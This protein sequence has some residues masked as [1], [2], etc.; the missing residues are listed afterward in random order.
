MKDE[1]ERLNL[2]LENVHRRDRIAAALLQLKEYGI[3]TAPYESAI[4]AIERELP[5][6]S[7]PKFVSLG[8]AMSMRRFLNDEIG[9]AK[10]RGLEVSE[11]E[12][13]IAGF[14]GDI[15]KLIVAHDEFASLLKKI[16]QK[17]L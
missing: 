17:S 16:K 6:K 2:V 3:A 15:E 14:E 1:L 5:D 4:V 12:N 13:A 11:D 8:N 10:K 9:R 7:L